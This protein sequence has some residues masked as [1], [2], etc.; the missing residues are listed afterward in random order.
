MRIIEKLL[1]SLRRYNVNIEEL[2]NPDNLDDLMEMFKDEELKN[3]LEKASDAYYNSDEKIMSDEEYDK[4]RDEY[5]SKIDLLPIGSP[6]KEGKGTVNVSHSYK[7][8]VG[9]LSKTN[10]IE[11]FKEWLNKTVTN[12]KGN[13]DKIPLLV[14]LKYDGN[15][16]AI[17]YSNGKCDVDVFCYLDEFANI[18]TNS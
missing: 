16:V 17:E 1:F 7:N 13:K 8:M 15:S 18:R 11:G 2:K 12:G 4:L 10:T 5:E 9:S 6:P 14:S 3:L